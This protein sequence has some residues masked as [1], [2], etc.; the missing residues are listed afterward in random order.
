MEIDLDFSE[1]VKVD[2]QCRTENKRIFAAGSC[3][4]I[5]YY[6]TRHRV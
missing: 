2:F 1:R 3:S 4:A 6:V 5:D